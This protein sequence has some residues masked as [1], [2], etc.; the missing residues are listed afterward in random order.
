M[1]LIDL[2]LCVHKILSFDGFGR[3]I[4]QMADAMLLSDK[5]DVHPYLMEQLEWPGTLQNAAGLDHSRLTMFLCPPNWIKKPA[6][7]RTWLLAMHES[8]KL[9]EGWAELVNQV[10][11]MIAPCEWVKTVYRESGVTIPISVVNPGVDFNECALLP[12]VRKGTRPYTF[13]ALGDRGLRKGW[14]T[15]YSAFF[16]AFRADDNVSLIIKSNL[17]GN[18]DRILSAN[19]SREGLQGRVRSWTERVANMRD[20]FAQTDCL[21]YPAHGEGWGLMNYS[22]L[23]VNCDR[24]AYPLNDWE[25]TPAPGEEDGLPGLWANPSI[26][27]VAERMRFCY[28]NQD[29]A[30]EKGLRSANWLRE[31]VTWAK[32]IDRLHEVFTE[33]D[34]VRVKRMREFEHPDTR[35]NVSLQDLKHIR[36][37][38]FEKVNSNGLH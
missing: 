31:N 9:P 7:S 4:R 21:V 28:E 30:R 37:Q 19:R 29:D 26:D 2:N 8:S 23:A 17:N 38:Q 14:S 3:Y 35:R 11:H 24:W 10:E 25:L 36:D 32:S 20:V 13:M 22:G 18:T 12:P 1:P 33:D 15:A 27:E 5:F 6:P 34:R 16:R